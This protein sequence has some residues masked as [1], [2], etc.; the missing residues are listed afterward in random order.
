MKNKQKLFRCFPKYRNIYFR[1][2]LFRETTQKHATFDRIN[3]DSSSDSN[4]NP[5][6]D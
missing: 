4:A 5:T 1:Y 2:F 3:S 6:D